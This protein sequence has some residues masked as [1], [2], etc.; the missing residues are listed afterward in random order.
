MSTILIFLVLVV[1][2]AA[3]VLLLVWEI[4]RARLIRRLSESEESLRRAQE[5]ASI[6]SWEFDAVTGDVIWSEE[7]YRIHG[8]PKGS[9]VTYQTVLN[10][11]H[12][13]D[14]QRL[15]EAWR[16]ASN[17]DNDVYDVVH[18]IVV[19]GK[20]KWVRAL[21]KMHFDDQG[22]VS[23][24]IGTTQD[25]TE[26]RRKD[27]ELMLAAS[28]YENTQEGIMVTDSAAVIL[29]VNPAFTAITGYTEE[30]V[31]GHTPQV[32]KS[33]RHDQTFYKEFREHLREDG[34]WEGTIWN[35]SKSGEL[36]L[37]S[38]KIS[39]IYD[40]AGRPDRYIVLISD[41]TE[42]W[43]KDKQIRFQAYHDTLT[44]LPNRQLLADRLEQAITRA[45]REGGTVAV[46]FIDLDNFKLINDSMGHSVGDHVLKVAAE[47]LSGLVRR[48]DTVARIGGDEFVI[49]LPSLS[50]PG[51]V[52]SV[53]EKILATLR[54][55][56]DVAGRAMHSSA[57]IG[58]AV[59]PDSG[60][61]AMGLLQNADTAMF[62]AK[63]A[64]KHLFRFYDDSMY[65]EVMQRLEMEASLREALLKQQ[66]EL[67]Y[68][69]KVDVRT[70]AVTAVE[71]LIRWHRPGYGLVMPGAFISLAEESH[72]IL[73]IGD[74]V[75]HEVCRQVAAWRSEGC[76]M[77]VAFNLSARQFEDEGLVD[78]VA[79]A[80]T[81]AGIPG[82]SLEVELTET[83][84]MQ[85]PQRATAVLHALRG[86]GIGVAI[87]DFGTG[88]SSLA[89]LRT[90]PIS[91]LKI[92]RSFV[93]AMTAG[94]SQWDQEIVRAIITLGRTLEIKI[95]A[96]GVETGEQLDYLK[97]MGCPLVQ[98]Y[99]FARPMPAAD[100]FAKGTTLLG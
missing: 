98:G 34:T 44:S 49:V 64:G 31:V 90:L 73:S 33:D 91:T 71:A 1:L 35:R 20:V 48:S 5:V 85:D 46:L 25:I 58:I 47:R 88:Y 80:L 52:A 66:F 15:D 27:E 51:L 6:G 96:E 79:T 37:M 68:Q 42:V 43:E 95:V 28:V 50:H 62:K 18:R 36:R 41:V 67:Y 2:V 38:E 60:S 97:R 14:R 72:L 93:H 3:G 53:A 40:E 55:P 13:Q 83:V 57:S 21:G 63:A 54:Q 89:Y 23:H 30:E 12:P 100:V 61:D 81:T 9:R 92:D 10:V 16:A 65:F 78:R 24:M 69:P 39:T 99:L 8:V 56:Y 70:G 82:S 29:A 86:L 32:M 87:D 84:T 22:R 17:P 45:R 94:S 7:E 11:V 77:K 59:Y 26:D 76:N 74:W 19:N 4:H 75:L